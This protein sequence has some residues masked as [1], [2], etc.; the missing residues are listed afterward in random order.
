MLHPQLPLNL[1]IREE[2]TF[3]NFVVGEN[4]DLVAQFKRLA[5]GE[6]T[7]LGYIWGNNGSGRTHLLQAA[8]H[9]AGDHQRTAIYLP[10]AELEILGPEVLQNIEGIDLVCIDDIDI[11]TGVRAWEEG[12]FHL[13]N[14]LMGAG[15]TLLVAGSANPANLGVGLLDLTSRL[16]SGLA[17]RIA[18]LRDEDLLTLLSDRA[19]GKGFEAR[20]ETLRYLLSRSHRSVPELLAALDQL[21]ASAMAAG[22]KLTI[23]LIKD[24]MSW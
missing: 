3:V 11:V 7:G 13:F 18:D 19:A 15:G 12:L 2:S 24:V 10:M 20:P 23:P 8:C 17:Y 4:G 22:R 9:L 16:G 14:R 21:D 1:P 5:G 6:D